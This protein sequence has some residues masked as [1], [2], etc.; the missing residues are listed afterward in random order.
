MEPS[1]NNTG[2]AHQN[3]SIESA[4]GH[5]ERASEDALLL[6]GTRAFTDLDAYRAF[7]DEIVGRR[8]G[9]VTLM[10]PAGWQR[11]DMHLPPLGSALRSNS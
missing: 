1:R 5:L 9:G 10:T 7:V 4:H 8:A 6:R 11:R 2:I 3:G